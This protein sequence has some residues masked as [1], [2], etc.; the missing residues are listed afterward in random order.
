MTGSSLVAFVAVGVITIGTAPAPLAA[1]AQ[2]AEPIPSAPRQV[3]VLALAPARPGL[4]AVAWP[5]LDSLEA[6]VAEQLREERE[7]IERVA[8]SA[9]SEGAT[10]KRAALAIASSATRALADAYG[11]LGETLHAYEFLE[12][13]D[14]SYRN[15]SR[16]SP[17][18]HRWL[19]LRGYL[20]QQSGRFEE[21]VELYGAA[22]RARSDDHAATV[23][24]GEVYLALGRFS[25]A[26]G[27]YQSARA[28]YPA[29]A[30][31]GLGEVALRQGRFVDA[32]DHFRAALERVPQATSIHYSLAMAFRGLGRPD[33]ARAHLGKRGPG[34]IRA[35]DPIVESLQTRVR[36]ERALIMQGR[37]AFEV[38][39]FQEAAAAFRQA[40]VAAP[41]SV[42]ARVNLGLTLARLGDMGAATTAL[43]AA[44]ALDGADVTALTGL[45]SVLAGQGRIAEAVPHLR[46]A[47]AQA[48]SDAALSRTLVGALLR[49]GRHDE[50]IGVLT[51]ARSFD[52]DD[53]DSLVG[54]SI[55]LSGRARFREAI[56]L[57]DEAHRR[58]PDRTATATTL[59]RLL[60]SSPELSLRDGQRALDLATAPAHGE[61]MA[62]AL[63]ELGRC[64]EATAWMQRA[65]TAAQLAK[66][67]VES[68][69]LRREVPK[70]EAESCRPSGR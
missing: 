70:Y 56:A 44:I 40:T 8:T 10:S 50:A 58:R 19:H 20:A 26:R 5:R 49:L 2:R 53:E 39:Q 48:P 34:G 42:A 41:A 21:A 62:L 22:R 37:R 28:R 12:A 67:A 6:A 66:D 24:L 36:G 65:V 33:D 64:A 32:R 27:E 59:A 9:A 52:P 23:R 29:A 31:S 13:A 54:L 30:E 51:A 47:F 63:A 7:A 1:G 35:V 14:A 45:G 55:L 46:S 4:E 16:L 57:L 38:G 17:R 11:S 61:T 3:D 43:D 60:A 68:E 15:A 69:R 25:D 18:D